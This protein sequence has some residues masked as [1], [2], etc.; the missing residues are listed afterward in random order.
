MK[1]ALMEVLTQHFRPE[2]LN[3]VDDVVVFHPLGRDQIRAIVDIQLG[4]LRKRLRE[5][6][7]DIT[8]SDAAITRLATAGYD[9][10]YGARPLKRAIH[11]N[12][13]LAQ[14][15]LKGNFQPGDTIHVDSGRSGMEFE[16]RRSRGAS[17]WTCDRR[18]GTRQ[19]RL[20]QRL[21]LL[22]SGLAPSGSSPA[23]ARA[24]PGGGSRNNSFS[25]PA[26]T[27]GRPLAAGGAVW[28][29]SAAAMYNRPVSGSMPMV[30][31]VTA[32]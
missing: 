9:P 16:R 22:Q 19:S 11:S 29:T 12:H 6:D 13:P 3:R 8:L 28:S 5:R 2:F 26:T 20:P 4:Y 31:P 27:C 30:R 23:S 1:T 24:L 7:I 18:P 15:I 17:D 32:V 25:E 21:T 10:V 14:E